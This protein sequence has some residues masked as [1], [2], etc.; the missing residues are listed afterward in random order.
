MGGSAGKPSWHR[1]STLNAL[2]VNS[3]RIRLMRDYALGRS[4]A[5]PLGSRGRN[6]PLHV[7][8]PPASG[9]RNKGMDASKV[10]HDL[11]ATVTVDRDGIIHEWGEAAT[12]VMGYSAGDTLGTSL[13]ATTPRRPRPRIVGLRQGDEELAD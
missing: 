13:D 11:R 12:E 4:L 5:G 10:T 6:Y 2:S 8:E 1:S 3:F 7:C 9:Y